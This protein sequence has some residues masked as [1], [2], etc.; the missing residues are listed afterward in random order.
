MDKVIHKELSYLVNGLLFKTHRELGRFRNEKQYADYF[1]KLLLKEGIEYVREYR[2]D[3]NRYGAGKTRC[4]CDFIIAGKIILEFKAKENISKD[5]YYQVK[6]YLVT[7][8]LELG[9]IVNFRQTRI[10]PKRVLNSSF[11]K[12][13]SFVS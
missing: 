10:I 5:E 13:L 1:E 4:I 3:D 7:L 2:F 11:F 6:R 8:N 12:K 9:I